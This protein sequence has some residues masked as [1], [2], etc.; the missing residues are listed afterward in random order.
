MGLRAILLLLVPFLSLS[1]ASFT[2]DT[3]DVPQL[4]LCTVSGSA[5]ATDADIAL[6]EAAA[7]NDLPGLRAALDR[8]AVIDARD[9]DART[10]LLIATHANHVDVAAA[11]IDAD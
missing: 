1:C 7:N 8:G 4:P 9:K 6:L 2:D 3:D 10:A 11:L 5:A